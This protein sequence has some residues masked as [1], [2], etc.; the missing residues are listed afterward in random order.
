MANNIIVA[1]LIHAGVYGDKKESKNSAVNALNNSDNT[2]RKNKNSEKKCFNSMNKNNYIYL[3][4][5]NNTVFNNMGVTLEEDGSLLLI[6]GKT[7]DLIMGEIEK[8]IKGGFVYNGFHIKEKDNPLMK[9]KEIYVDSNKDLIGSE[10]IGNYVNGNKETGNKL[11]KIKFNKIENKYDLNERKSDNRSNKKTQ[12][13]V[14]DK[15]SLDD[16]L[17][18][19][20]IACEEYTPDPTEKHDLSSLNNIVEQQENN[21]LKVNRQGLRFTIS[22]KDNQLFVSGLPATLSEDEVDSKDKEYLVKLPLKPKDKIVAIKP[23]SDQIQIIVDREEKT[24]IYY[25]NPSL[26]FAIKDYDYKIRRLEQQPPLS[27][28]SLVGENNYNNYHSGQPFSSQ[29]A[30]NFSSRHIPFFSSVIDNFRIHVGKAKQQRALKNYKTMKLNIVKS[31]DPGFRGLFSNIKGFLNTSTTPCD[32]KYKALHSAKANKESL[33]AVLNNYVSGISNRKT[34]GEVVYSIV[35]D[36]KEKNSITIANDNSSRAFFGTSAFNLTKKINVNV[37]LLASYSKTHS[38][39]LSKN[40]NN[41]VKFSFINKKEA[42]LSVGLSAGIGGHKKRW[43]KSNTDYGV[44]TPIL[45]ST[46]LS[47]N[48]ERESNFSFEID[49]ND[50]VEFIDKE[51]DISS[52]KLENHTTFNDNKNISAGISFDIRSELS[53]DVNLKIGSNI[54]AT[55]PRNAVGTSAIASLLKLN[56]N[57]NKFFDYG[58]I[59]FAEKDTVIDLKLFEILIDVYRDLKFFPSTTR[60]TNEIQWYPLATMKNFEFMLQKKINNL[61]NI[62]IF[63]SKK[64]KDEKEFENNRRELKDIYKRILKTNKLFDQ[65]PT[66]VNVNKTINKLDSVYLKMLSNK[67]TIDKIHK[68]N[69]INYIDDTDNHDD[70]TNY[71]AEVS[72]YLDSLSVKKRKLQQF[73]LDLKEKKMILSSQEKKNMNEKFESYSIFKYKLNERSENIYK[74]TRDEFYEMIKNI[75]TNKYLSLKNIKNELDNLFNKCDKELN[76]MEYK[77]DSIDIM[78][79]SEISDKVKSVPLVLVKLEKKKGI[80][81]HQIKGEIKFNYDK[82]D[83]KLE[84]I[85]TSYYF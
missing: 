13:K 7:Q 62:N 3:G 35:K 22:L 45:A 64:L 33:Y 56:I 20:H 83:K 52:S 19:I 12:D 65:H 14:T 48:Y 18:N 46:Y 2:Y 34:Q 5:T 6:R 40:E 81:H 73:L 32:D 74:N 38:L 36:L 47:L 9:F 75:K 51:L 16:G 10:R 30:G 23:V 68:D 25:M 53:A 80:I 11:Y 24:K 77:L 37:F 26:I 59:D 31:V 43:Q 58:K 78:S 70:V 17:G 4:S 85:S 82:Y 42:D 72:K 44:M 60:T 54:E 67:K 49:L 61:F 79:I 8:H 39:T 28:Y 55:I 41:Q 50:V 63:D 66:S 57:I 29:S 21:I 69:F 71:S 27:F 76:R 1:K 15:K 84:N